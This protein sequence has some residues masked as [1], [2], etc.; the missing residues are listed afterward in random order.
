MKMA[1]NDKISQIHSFCPG[2]GYGIV[3]RLI[4][5]V[6]GELGLDESI[7][8]VSDVACNS[9]AV[10]SLKYDW[11]VAPHGRVAAV[12]SGVKRAKSE[13]P[14]LAFMGDG[15]AYSIGFAE[16]M[17]SAIRNEKITTIVV[18][19][20]V[21]A[22]TGGQMSPTTLVGQ[23]TS[24]SLKGRNEKT[25]GKPLDFKD[26]MEHLDVAYLARGSIHN[27]A[28]IAKT[29]KYIKE[30]F[31]S[32]MNDEGFSLVEILSPCPTNWNLP[33]QKAMDKIVKEMI[34]VFPI[35]EIKAREVQ[36]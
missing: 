11:I 24:T 30:A 13:R 5:E 7:N 29:K 19:N 8:A 1:L 35:G 2:C 33:P 36:R 18:N 3:I 32:Q 10:Y 31:S 25:M 14:V 21:F 12:A 9:L 17:H 22:M 28:E 34:P 6:L 26:Y 15:A 27:V 23:K 16:T 4:N 20:N